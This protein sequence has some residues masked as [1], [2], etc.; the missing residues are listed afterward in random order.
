[1]YTELLL[2]TYRSFSKVHSV[3]NL[4]KNVDEFLKGELFFLNSLTRQRNNRIYTYV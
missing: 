3:V 4:K 2:Y 1:M